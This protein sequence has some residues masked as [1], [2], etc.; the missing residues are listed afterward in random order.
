MLPCV[1]AT[2]TPD[3]QYMDIYMKDK[4]QELL[5]P[6]IEQLCKRLINSAIGGG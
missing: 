2:E 3:W 1:E 6:T 5:K 4:E